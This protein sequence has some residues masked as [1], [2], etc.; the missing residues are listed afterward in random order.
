[1]LDFDLFDVGGGNTHA[2]VLNAWAELGAFGA[3]QTDTLFMDIDTFPNTIDYWGPSGMVYLR[4]PQVRYTPI[5]REGMKVAFSLEAPNSAIDTGKVAV[6]DPA[7]GASITGHSRYPDLVG[8]VRF[9]R[10]WGHFQAAAILRSVGFETQGSP[11]SEPSGAETGYGLNLSGHWNTPGGNRV[12]GQIVY[13]RGIASYMNDGGADLAP[14]GSFHAEAVKTVGWFVYYDHNWNDQW[15]A[16]W[17]TASIARATPAGSSARRSRKAAMP[18]P[19]CCIRRSR[20]SPS[21]RSSCGA[22]TSRRA[23]RPAMTP[24]SSSRPGTPS[25]ETL[26]MR[27]TVVPADAGTHVFQKANWAPA[28]AGATSSDLPR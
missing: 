20:T 27:P 21:A 3:G 19:T 8:N 17:A 5:R 26:K 4:N 13:G 6:A 28:F 9:D 2:R 15:T 18:P 1:M 22:S 11:N 23:A 24:A 14:D 7:L 25:R 10:D 16:P 12:V